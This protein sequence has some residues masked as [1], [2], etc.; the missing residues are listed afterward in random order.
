MND[1]NRSIDNAKKEI[2]SLEKTIDSYIEKKEEVVINNIDL[3]FVDNC[4]Y[5][6]Q[7][8]PD[9]KAE[10]LREKFNLTKSNTLEKIVADG[11]SLNVKM[12]EIEEKIADQE[13][14]LIVKRLVKLL[15]KLKG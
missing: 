15:N 13:A 7:P 12:K 9:H 3:E 10:E 5:C 11:K 1:L 14:I 8:L 2:E 4:S 6:G